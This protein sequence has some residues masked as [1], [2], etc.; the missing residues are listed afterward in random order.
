MDTFIEYQ[1]VT[2]R[3]GR[4]EVLKGVD[5]TVRKGETLVILGGSGTGKSVLLKLTIGLF[6]ADEGKI[7]VSGQDVTG[8][9][10]P[11]W[12]DVRDRISYMFQ[13][14]ALFDSLT[15]YD[16]VAFPLREHHACDEAE[17]DRRVMEKLGL[18]GLESARDVYPS[19]LSGGMRKRASLARSIVMQPDCIL[20]DEPTSG[21]DPITAD[22]INRLIIR[23]QEVLGVTSV[24][25]THDIQSMFRVAD[26][27][28]FL[29]QGTMAFVG[30][31]EEARQADHPVLRGFIEGR[32]PDER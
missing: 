18:V 24:I 10:E 23:M 4:N 5:L 25:V 28:A 16:N 31:P 27:L 26:R 14:G 7:L 32:D 11:Q 6:E 29:Y 2:K 21:L 30:S 22:T 19:D 20:Y 1:G 9:A 13:W 15:V 8:Y 12:M 17:V 3:F